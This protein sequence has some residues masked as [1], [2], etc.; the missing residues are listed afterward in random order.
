MKSG[1]AIA[2]YTVVEELGAASTG[3]EFLATPPAR[4]SLCV[5]LVVLKLVAGGSP[6]KFERF[7]RELQLFAQVQSPYLVELYDAGQFDDWFFLTREHCTGGSLTQCDALSRPQRRNAVADAARAAQALHTIN[8]VHTDIRPGTVLLRGNGSAVLA[9]LGL[10]RIETGSMSAMAPT[11]AVGFL[12]PAL[13]LGDAPT[14]AADV[15]SL[16]AVLHYVLTGQHL[17]PG[18]D[19]NEPLKAVRA[20]LRADARPVRELLT[21][22]EADLI[23]AS[24]TKD[25]ARRIPSAAE[26]ATLV[27]GLQGE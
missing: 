26:F 1:T 8:V 12:D 11:E 16:G 15:F 9:D 22:E 18:I 4:L 27:E 25:V 20:V 5:D 7:T 21:A 17:F 23:A 24:T 19:P 13:L 6:K 14:P 3:R 2:D 10:A